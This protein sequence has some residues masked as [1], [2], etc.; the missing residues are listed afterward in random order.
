M[1][2]LFHLS[3]S[4][5]SLPFHHSKGFLH[6]VIGRPL[7]ILP[8]TTNQALY[9]LVVEAASLSGFGHIALDPLC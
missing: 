5:L 7:L 4:E 1:A 8:T 6:F 9:L 2:T 3:L